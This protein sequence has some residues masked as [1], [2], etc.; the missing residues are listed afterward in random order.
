MIRYIIKYSI[1]FILF[2]LLIFISYKVFTTSNVVSNNWIVIYIKDILKSPNQIDDQ[3]QKI[4]QLNSEIN[5]LQSKFDFLTRSQVQQK[6]ISKLNKEYT[7][8]VHPIPFPGYNEFGG[9]PTGYVEVF[10]D[11]LIIASGTGDF[12]YVENFNSNSKIKLTKIKT[13]LKKLIKDPSF[14]G[15]GKPSVRDL[16]IDGNKIYVGYLK[17]IYKKETCYNTAILEAEIDIKN[18]NLEFKEFFDL[19]ECKNLKSNNAVYKQLFRV[20]L[21]GGRVAKLDENHILLTTGAMGDRPAAQDL[22]SLFGKILSINLDTKDYRMVAMGLRN[23]QGLYYD[24]EKNIL[25]STDHGPKGGDEVNL[26]LDP[27]KDPIENY[28]WPISS[29]GDHY[30]GKELPEAPL[31]KS[32]SDYGFIE[33]IKYFTPSVAVS[34]I[35][36]VK[37]SFDE[38][39]TNEYFV[40]AMGYDFQLE[41]GDR[42]LHRFKWSEDFKTILEHDQILIGERIRD[43]IYVPNINAYAMTL[44]NQS[45]AILYKD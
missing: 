14:F 7:L 31:N 2:F 45:L 8:K 40:A 18:F 9:K 39:A 11:N 35:Y 38:N 33:P 29:Y 1:I 16:F 32:H 13:N 12:Y 20:E 19:D 42:H 4:R 27:F 26:N 43:I 15:F 34:Q 36:K 21:M 10:N 22:K 41:E 37:K 6:L 17:T 23:P 3:K 25:L 30:D 44:E 28:G 5:L 24:D